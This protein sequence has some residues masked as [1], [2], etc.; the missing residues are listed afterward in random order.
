M[1]RKSAIAKFEAACKLLNEVSD[2]GYDLYVAGSGSFH[3]MRGPSHDLMCKRA[4]QDNVVHTVGV[5]RM[6]GGDW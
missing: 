4:L 2:A 6:S 3:L 1:S 5:R